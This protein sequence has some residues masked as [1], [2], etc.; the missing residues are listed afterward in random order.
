M[1]ADLPKPSIDPASAKLP[2]GEPKAIRYAATRLEQPSRRAS[3]LPSPSRSRIH[4][5]IS[6]TPCKFALAQSFEAAAD[7]VHLFL[8][9]PRHLFRLVRHAQSLGLLLCRRPA[10]PSRRQ[11]RPRSARRAHDLG[12]DRHSRRQRLHGRGRLPP[13]C[14]GRGRG[15]VPCCLDAEAGGAGAS[16]GEQGEEEHEQGEGEGGWR[17]FAQVGPGWVGARVVGWRQ[18]A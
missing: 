16:A 8:C 12:H 9:R 6:G 2:A 11:P 4:A 18:D 13:V 17:D 7:P 5:A 14:A 3:H 1:Q 15:A 10:H